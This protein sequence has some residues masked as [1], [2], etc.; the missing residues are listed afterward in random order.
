MEGDSLIIKYVSC[1]GISEPIEHI[2][3]IDFYQDF[4]N[5]NKT[6]VICERSKCSRYYEEGYETFEVPVEKIIYIK[7]DL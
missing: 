6:L 2:D 1:D 7:E 4:F 3:K 5:E